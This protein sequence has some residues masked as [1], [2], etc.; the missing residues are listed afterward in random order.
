M[1]LRLLITGG[2]G[3]VGRAVARVA[4]AQDYEVAVFSHSEERQR[5]MRV[6]MPEGALT[7][8]LGDVRDERAV[9]HAVDGYAPD[10]ILHLAA[11]KQVPACEA[12]PFEAVQTNVTGTLHVLR[13]GW[14]SQVI[15]MSTDKACRPTNVY[16]GT[17]AMAE[18]LA[19]AAGQM[20][21]RCGNILE[22][23]G[24]VL[25]LWRRQAAEGQPLTVTDP[26]M[27]RF[28]VCAKAVAYML[29]WTFQAFR[30]GDVMVPKL[31]ACRLGT[32]ADLIS[33]VHQIIGPRAGERQHEWLVAP[34]EPVEDRGWAYVI[35]KLGI[36]RE[37]PYAS[38]TAEEIVPEMEGVLA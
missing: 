1:S 2:T 19:V 28:F 14:R 5:Q 15:V 22:S 27:T 30:P 36:P 11:M 21:F 33:G 34:E 7:F 32:L 4:I 12:F 10:Q 8:I 37:T 23:T 17:K 13:A 9:V 20:A 31:K 24:S 29:W 35:T 25:P 3:T 38:D 26:E 18:R 16:G 6:E